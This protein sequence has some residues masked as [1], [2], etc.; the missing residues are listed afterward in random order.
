[1]NMCLIL[2]CYL[3]IAVLIYKYKNN[4]SGNNEREISYC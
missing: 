1:M 2:N 3:D 4:V